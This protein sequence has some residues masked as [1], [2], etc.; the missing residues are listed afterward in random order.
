MNVIN[1]GI[2]DG[3]VTNAK[4]ANTTILPGK[5]NPQIGNVYLA[6]DTALAVGGTWYQL[7]DMAATVGSSYLV[8]VHVTA[9]TT[10][11]SDKMII[12]VYNG[13]DTFLSTVVGFTAGDD[14]ASVSLTGFNTA[15]AG[16]TY[17][18]AQSGSG[19]VTVK[20]NE[21]GGTAD[22]LCLTFQVG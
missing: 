20:Y 19:D 21:S 15:T 13:A 4:L 9:K 17:V 14:S 10:L 2:P 18:R 1:T 12:E 8:F 5:M 7:W 11:I 16:H 3:A 22:S 6:A